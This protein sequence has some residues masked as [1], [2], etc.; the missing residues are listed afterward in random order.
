ESA[1][2]ER[3]GARRFKPT[4]RLPADR[5]PDGFPLM[6]FKIRA[7]ASAGIGHAKAQRL[8]VADLPHFGGQVAQSADVVAHWGP[9]SILPNVTAR[10][11]G[12]MAGWRRNGGAS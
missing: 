11:L 8:V 3:I 12:R 4:S 2:M 10:A 7:C 6:P 1:L 5:V 9:G